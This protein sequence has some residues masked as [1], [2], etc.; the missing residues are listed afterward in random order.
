MPRIVDHDQR[1][2]DLAEVAMNIVAQEGIEAMTIANVAAKSGYSTGVINHYY[3]N[4]RQMLLH[5]YKNTVDQARTRLEKLVSQEPPDIDACLS[6]FLP[7]NPAPRVAPL[8]R[9]LG[10]GYYRQGIRGG[11]AAAPSGRSK[12]FSVGI[13]RSHCRGSPSG[14][15]R[16]R[17]PEYSLHFIDQRNRNTGCI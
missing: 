1:R 12:A 5:T 3:S 2:Q 17:V 16:L 8:V 6:T 11:T 13:L 10:N 14:E 15:F 7:L 4:K 9:F